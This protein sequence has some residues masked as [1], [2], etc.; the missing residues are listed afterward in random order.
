[1]EEEREF[2]KNIYCC[3]ID[4]TKLFVW[5]TAN[6]AK[7]LTRWEYHITLLVS[8]ETC[9][10]IKKHHLELDMEQWT[11]STGKGDQG[12]ILSPRL[13]N[14]YVDC[15]VWNDRLDES[16]ARIEITRRNN[17]LRYA[18]DSILMAESEEELKSLLMRMKEESEENWL[19]TQYSKH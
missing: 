9:M 14:L 8:W 19:E 4:Y 5:I 15:I 12:C 3:F 17:S 1:M 16:Q 6:C 7:F 18:D 10:Q 13:F 11:S 2:Q